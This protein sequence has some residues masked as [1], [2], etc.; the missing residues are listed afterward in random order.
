MS[1]YIYTYIH[2][3]I[4]IHA[5]VYTYMDTD[6]SPTLPFPP[7]EP[8]SCMIQKAFLISAHM[9][10]MAH[11][12]IHL[13]VHSYTRTHFETILRNSALKRIIDCL[14]S[15]FDVEHSHL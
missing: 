9:Q 13:E 6:D 2:I 14:V 12:F 8:V 15:D 10:D 4:Y 11:T 5:C 3:Y 1:I 7:A